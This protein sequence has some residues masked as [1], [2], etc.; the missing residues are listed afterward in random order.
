MTKIK[1]LGTVLGIWAHP[2][3][4]AYLSAGLMAAARREGQ[5]VAVWTATAGELG[6]DDPVR[7]PPARLGPHRRRELAAA[8][9]A[10]GV[11]DHMV[12]GYPDGGCAAVPMADGMAAVR[13]VVDAVEPDT[14]VTFGP[15]GMTGHPDHVAVSAWTT[16]WWQSM[17]ACADVR[18]IYATVTPAFRTRWRSVNDAIG[19]WGGG[20]GPCTPADDLAFEVVCDDELLTRKLVALHAHRSQTEPL[21]RRVGSAA[22]A[23]WWAVE[24]FVDAPCRGANGRWTRVPAHIGRS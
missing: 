3:D 5:R 18:L 13:A 4:E 16:A 12:H 17:G 7:W 23:G 1:D 19:L 9:A 24:S 14:I 21:E 22:Y 2:D 10:L 6:T 8:L 15:D 20:Q 11:H